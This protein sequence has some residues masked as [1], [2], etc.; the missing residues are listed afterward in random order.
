MLSCIANDAS[1]YYSDNPFEFIIR[2]SGRCIVGIRYL[3]VLASFF[4][5]SRS[6]LITLVQW[7][8]IDYFIS[9]LSLLDRYRH[10]AVSK[11]Y[12]YSLLVGSR[13][14]SLYS[15]FLT[16]KWLGAGVALPDLFL[17]NSPAYFIT[18]AKYW[19]I[20]ILHSSIFEKSNIMPRC[21]STYCWLIVALFVQT[22]FLVHLWFVLQPLDLHVR[23]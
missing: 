12:Y 9:D 19:N 21:A 3:I 13:S 16:Y 14:T 7:Y 5:S 17:Y 10:Y 20:D 4:W 8:T 2:I 6:S 22:Y 15:G 18:L 1:T 11:C 23:S